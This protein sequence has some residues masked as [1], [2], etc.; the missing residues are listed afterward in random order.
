MSMRWESL[1]FAHWPVAEDQIRPHIPSNLEIDTFNGESWI[2]V[3]PFLMNAVHPRWIPSL[4]CVS[5]FPELNVRT[6]V[7]AEGKPGV[8]FFSLEAANPLAVW[9]AR[10]KYY[11]PYFHAQM[12]IHKQNETFIYDSQRTHRGAP[13][14][15]F[16]GEYGPCGEVYLASKGNLD[17]WLTERYCLYSANRHGTVY[18]GEIHH[19]PWPLQPA[20]A[21][22][23]INTM[24]DSHRI[25]TEDTAPLLHFARGVD[26]IAW[27]VV[28]V[29]K[30]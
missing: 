20:K 18:R 11:L 23:N 24:I 28:Q 3:V 7:K 1:L 5:R 9:M 13:E 10:W 29:N 4:P 15:Q 22:I 6:Y 25:Q 8:W 27:P 19:D 14:A 12:N 2:G 30:K 17:H 21:K 16:S 26:V